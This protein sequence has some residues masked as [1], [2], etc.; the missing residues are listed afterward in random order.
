MN[1][2]TGLGEPASKEVSLQEEEK[3]FKEGVKSLKAAI[4][5]LIQLRATLNDKLSEAQTQ[6]R[7]SSE[8]L[9][10]YLEGACYPLKHELEVLKK[11]NDQAFATE[12]KLNECAEGFRSGIKDLY[13]KVQALAGMHLQTELQMV[14]HG[15]ELRFQKLIQEEPLIIKELCGKADLLRMDLQTCATTDSLEHMEER[16]YH[17]WQREFEH[18]KTVQARYLK[19]DLSP[20]QEKVIDI[21]MKEMELFGSSQLKFVKGNF[22]LLSDEV[23]LPTQEEW[24]ASTHHYQDKCKTIK[25]QCVNRWNQSVLHIIVCDVKLMLIKDV[26]FHINELQTWM[27]HFG[28]CRKS[29]EK[30]RHEFKGS[31]KDKTISREHVGDRV[32]LKNEFTSLKVHFSNLIAGWKTYARKLQDT[33]KLYEEKLADYAGQEKL[34]YATEDHPIE[35]FQAQFK[36][37]LEKDVR[38]WIIPVQTHFQTQMAAIIKNVDECAFWMDATDCVDRNPTWT[39][40]GGYANTTLFPTR[41]L[42]TKNYTKAYTSYTTYREMTK[43]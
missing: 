2:L 35:S 10:G 34:G 43:G 19:K 29:L 14:K 16:A 6:T 15:F 31:E 24:D 42:F 17:G 13:E 41:T 12:V 1:L 22:T 18:L 26:K 11:G 36:V 23:P 27:E 20:A 21:F 40:T 8:L 25:K 37:C 3:D 4:D 28:E 7:H 38:G 32:W 39:Y 33:F 9:K 30:L 5:T